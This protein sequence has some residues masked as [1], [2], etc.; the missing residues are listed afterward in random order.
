MTF[1]T[2]S[3][4]GLQLGLFDPSPSA[5]RSAWF[6]DHFI[7]NSARIAWSFGQLRSARDLDRQ[8]PAVRHSVSLNV[9]SNPQ[10]VTMLELVETSIDQ[11]TLP[12]HH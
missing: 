11:E 3:K 7:C 8:Q 10:G 9:Q 4:T 1:A 5:Q 2:T 6:L 12:Q